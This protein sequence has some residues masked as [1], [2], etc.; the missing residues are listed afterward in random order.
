VNLARPRPRRARSPPDS[1][2]R[3][4]TD[5]LV[6]RAAIGVAFSPA[7]KAAQTQRGSRR[8]YAR[9]EAGDGWPN[10]ITADLAAADVEKA[11]AERDARIRMLEAE[12]AALR[13]PT[14]AG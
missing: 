5:F 6:G 9:V 4:R 12:I 10:R 14:S 1:A 11:L 13:D 8:L 3:N 7:V 2:W